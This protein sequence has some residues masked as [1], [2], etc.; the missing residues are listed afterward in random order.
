MDTR[1]G[2][3]QEA[4]G[5]ACLRS[6]SGSDPSVRCD[7]WLVQWLV[8]IWATGFTVVLIVGVLTGRVP[9][10]DERERLRPGPAAL[11]VV[12]G[13]VFVGIVLSALLE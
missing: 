2:P 12:L 5:S 9:V 1:R 8:S 7:P 11:V 6:Q 4:G 10:R 3:P 13:V